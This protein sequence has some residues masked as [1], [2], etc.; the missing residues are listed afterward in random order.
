MLA[1]RPEFKHDVKLQETPQ[2]CEKLNC[3]K[4]CET[5][6]MLE[7]AAGQLRLNTE[8]CKFSNRR[9]LVAGGK[10]IQIFYYQS[11]FLFQTVLEVLL[12]PSGTGS[13]SEETQRGKS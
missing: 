6:S 12:C 13:L 1:V 5:K 9:T 2:T 10:T 8:H 7:K 11:A 4:Y 3:F